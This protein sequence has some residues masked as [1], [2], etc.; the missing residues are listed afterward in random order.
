MD[1]AAGRILKKL[2][3]LNEASNTLVIFTSDNG[4]YRTDRANNRNLKGRKNT[5]LGRGHPRPRNHQVA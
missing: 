1:H 3:T 4:S 5:A 2:E